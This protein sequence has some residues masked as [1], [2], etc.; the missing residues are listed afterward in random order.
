MVIR[1]IGRVRF[2]VEPEKAD[3][4]TK[5]LLEENYWLPNINN[6]DR[7]FITQDDNEGNAASGLSVMFSEDGDAWVKT[8]DK[9]MESCRF[10]TYAGGGRSHRVRNA[11]MI[12]AEAIRLD[13]QERESLLGSTHA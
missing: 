6:T 8:Y 10:R 12:L 13:S 11:L 3:K 2:I 1:I 5:E 7:Y 9:P 4:L